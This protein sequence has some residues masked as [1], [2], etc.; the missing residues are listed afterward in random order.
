MGSQLIDAATNYELC[1]GTVLFM[2]IGIKQNTSYII[3]SVQEKNIHADWLKNE[4]IGC[5][6]VLTDCGFKVR[7]VTSDNHPCN[8]SSYH[9]ILNHFNTP[10]D[11]LYFMY[12]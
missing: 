1:K 10:Y 2:I 9:K 7:M 5:L 6:K 4:I 12:E 3:K 8:T 11:N